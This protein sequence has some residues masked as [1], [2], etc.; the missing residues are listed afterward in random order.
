M[1]PKMAYHSPVSDMRLP[2]RYISKL[3]IVVVQSR[4]RLPKRYMSKLYMKCKVNR[5]LLVSKQVW[6]VDS[7]GCSPCAALN[8]TKMFLTL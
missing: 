6:V 4:K 1:I 8:S 5:V 2:K 7:E 3:F